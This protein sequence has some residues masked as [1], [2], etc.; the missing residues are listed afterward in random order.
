[1]K[2]FMCDKEINEDEKT[3]EEGVCS[4]CYEAMRSLYPNDKK[5]N[6]RLKCHKKQAKKLKQ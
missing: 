4:T 2:C 3:V 1:M 5:L 6:A